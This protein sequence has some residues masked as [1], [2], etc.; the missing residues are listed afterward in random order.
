V[1]LLM[2]HCQL[3]TQLVKLQ[4]DKIRSHLA[5]FVRARRGGASASVRWLAAFLPF[6][7]Q[8]WLVQ[9]HLAV[10]EAIKAARLEEDFQIDSW[11]LVEGGH[12]IDIADAKVRIAA[13]S[14][15]VRLL[16]HS[17]C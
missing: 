17:N 16:E 9:G 8:L 3:G 7:K 6:S 13:P 4:V 12:D 1:R 14:V 2:A 10:A 5:R 15:F 11:G